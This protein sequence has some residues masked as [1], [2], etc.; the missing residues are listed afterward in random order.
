MNLRYA[1][2]WSHPNGL[3]QLPDIL[4]MGRIGL[5]PLNNGY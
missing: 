2:R 4:G 5:L 1:V 3:Q